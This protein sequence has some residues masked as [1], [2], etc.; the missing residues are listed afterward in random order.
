MKLLKNGEF[1]VLDKLRKVRNKTVHEGYICSKEEAE[2]GFN[3]AKEILQNQL[4]DLMFNAEV[5][6]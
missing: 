4:R 1:N 5:S 3:S 2:T 6:K